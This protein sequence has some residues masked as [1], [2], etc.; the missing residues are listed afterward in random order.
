VPVQ[1]VGTRGLQRGGR[2]SDHEDHGGEHEFDE[3]AAAPAGCGASSLGTM[4]HDER[5]R[6]IAPG[7]D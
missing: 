4:G 1:L 3:T 5:A 6:Q 7:A 2:D